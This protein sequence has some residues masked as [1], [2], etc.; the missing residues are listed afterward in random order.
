MSPLARSLLALAVVAL[1]H[2][3][4]AN[5][6]RKAR[7]GEDT[8]VSLGK[9]EGSDITIL[10]QF[11]IGVPDV[12]LTMPNDCDP[13]GYLRRDLLGSVVIISNNEGGPAPVVI[14]ADPNDPQS[15]LEVR[16][17]VETDDDGNEFRCLGGLDV[18]VY[19][20]CRQRLL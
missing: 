4:C 2:S 17:Q 7:A 1:L 3:A 16:C 18:K 11:H 5:H 15:D 9:I 10:P 20:F 19:Q 8:S 13:Y 12:V 14:P 6:R